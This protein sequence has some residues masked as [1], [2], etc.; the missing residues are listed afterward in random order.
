MKILI[1]GNEGF[2]G[3]HLHKLIP[4]ADGLDLKSGQDIRTCKLDK[5]YTHV[6]HLAALRKP[7]EA[8]EIPEAYISTNCFGTVRL[9][10]R[11]PNARFLNVTSASA[12]HVVGVYGSTKKFAEL[13]GALHLNSVNVRP[14]NIFG[15][16]QEHESNTAIPN[17]INCLLTGNRPILYGDGDYVRDF[18]YVGDLVIELKRLMFSNETGL[19]HAGYSR[20]TT[21]KEILKQIYGGVMPDIDWKPARLT[22]YRISVSP[23]AIDESIGRNEGLKRTVDWWK[24]KY[25][26]RNLP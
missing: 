10:K 22:D 5:E 2:I 20:H 7:V 13:V 3:S 9:L 6:F 23:Y 16:G 11:Y 19:R 26:M 18:T 25:E 24:K 21:V 1:T 12:E 17:F 15:E 8:E 14:Y 4:E